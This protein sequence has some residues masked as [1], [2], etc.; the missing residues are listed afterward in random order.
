[1]R[2]FHQTVEDLGK[3]TKIHHVFFMKNDN[4]ILLE[5]RIQQRRKELD[6]VRQKSNR[7]NSSFSHLQSDTDRLM[8]MIEKSPEVSKII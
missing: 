5:T 8:H 3:E 6:D 4:N 1:M 7:F 2:N